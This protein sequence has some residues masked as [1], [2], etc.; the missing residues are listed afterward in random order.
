M[1]DEDLLAASVVKPTGRSETWTVMSNSAHRWFFKNEQQPDEVVLI[2]CF[3]SDTSVARRV[4]HSA[5]KDGD[6]DEAPNRQS[7]EVRALVLYGEA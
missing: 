7:I 1:A 5:F 4:P 3:D 2:K 6:R